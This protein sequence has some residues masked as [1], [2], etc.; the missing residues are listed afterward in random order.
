MKL[1]E[2]YDLHAEEIREL[3]YLKKA[4]SQSYLDSLKKLLKL[5]ISDNEVY[6]LAFG[7]HREDSNLHQRPLS[8]LKRDILIELGLIK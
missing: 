4:Y 3:I 2:M 5:P 7:V 1:K 6:L 8:K